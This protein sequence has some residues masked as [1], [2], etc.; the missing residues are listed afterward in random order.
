VLPR[1]LGERERHLAPRFPSGIVAPDHQE[2][3]GDDGR[4]ELARRGQLGFLDDP[5]GRLLERVDGE[6]QPAGSRQQLRRLRDD[7]GAVRVVDQQ[8]GGVAAELTRDRELEADELLILD[9]RAVMLGEH[10]PERLPLIHCH[11]QKGAARTGE[12]VKRDHNP[13]SV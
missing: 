5:A 3:Q 11:H 12:R 13:P 10:R 4:V 1:Q 2:L 6:D 9:R 8:A 7:L